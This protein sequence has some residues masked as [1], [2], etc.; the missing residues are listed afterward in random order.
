MIGLIVLKDKHIQTIFQQKNESDKA[1]G[2]NDEE[3]VIEFE[4]KF[5][6]IKVDRKIDDQND[7]KSKQ[8]KQV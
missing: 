6:F 5:Y 7:E 8:L 1:Y 4:G 3:E 2:G